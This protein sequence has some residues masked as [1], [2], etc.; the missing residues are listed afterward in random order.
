MSGAS[1]DRS[2]RRGRDA[3]DPTEIPATSWKD[4]AVRVYR[5]FGEDHVT[6]TAAGVAFFG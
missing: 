1:S 6:L 3:G 4:I 2:D 5:Q